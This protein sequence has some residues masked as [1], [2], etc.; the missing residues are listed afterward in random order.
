MTAATLSEHASKNLL[1]EYGVPICREA[2]G[3]DAAAAAAAAEQI[4]FPVALK[5][6]GDAIAHKTERDLVRLG[7]GDKAAVQGAAE[8]L[9]ARA[10]PEDGAVELL[11]AEMVAGRRELI[12]GLVRD[13]QF[14]PCVVLGLGGILTE[15]LK[16]VAFAAVPIDRAAAR[17]LIGRLR[18]S[19]LITEPF[20]GEPAADLDALA[21]VLVGLSRLAE[22]RPDIASVDVNPLILRDGKPVAVDGLVELGDA[23]A[24]LTGSTAAAG[25]P[26]PTDASL[27]ER[28]RPLFQPR[29]IVIAGVSSHPGKFGFVTYHNLLRFGYQGK[30]FPVTRDGGEILGRPTLAGISEVPSGEADLVFVCTPYQANIELL[31]VCAERGIRAAFIASGGYGEAGEEGREREQELI[32][33]AD[34]LGMVV[35]GPNGQGVISTGPS[36]CA[37]IVAPYPPAGRISVASQ[38]GNLVSSF[39]NY[40]VLTGVG[41]SKAVSAGN[42]AQTSVPDFLE[43]FAAD[44]ET[45]VALTYLE[46]IPD[47]RRFAEAA[48]RVTAKKPLVLVKGGVAAEGKRAAASH[49]GSLASD[50][51]VFDGIARQVGAIRAPSVEHAFEWAATFATQPLP[52][53]RRTIVFTTAGGWGVLAADACAEAGLELMKLPED[54]RAKIDGMVPPRWSRS[55]PIDLAGGETR[56]TIPEVLDLICAHPEVD[57]VIHLGLGIQASQ[58][59]AFRSGEFHPDFGLDRIADFHARQDR[60]YA[61]AAREASERHDKPVLSA[62][63]LVYADRAYGNSGPVGVREEGRVCYPSAHRAVAALRALVEYAEFRRS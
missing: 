1:A 47:G 42:S 27:I 23:A 52:R 25:S 34:E 38:S 50:D 61:Q 30:L 60:R 53:G 57:A 21:D 43:Y 59:E 55:N 39:L 9:L 56:D 7:L 44:P 40:A 32:R 37:Q 3:A 15:A 18:T 14:G 4:G 17:G 8:E 51:R 5:L 28:F 20:R 26:P 11:V 24:P 54:L 46:G 45:A 19:H 48:R 12:A 35:A 10:T 63:E 6:C 58:A 41:I 62:T 31:R 36:M 2:V 49:T 16:D 22:A 33:V 13:P 29:G